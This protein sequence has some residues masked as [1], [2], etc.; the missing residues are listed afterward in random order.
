[1]RKALANEWLRGLSSA[2]AQHLRR[3]WAAP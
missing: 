2:A 3:R 1:V